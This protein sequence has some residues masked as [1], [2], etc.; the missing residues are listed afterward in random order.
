M[1]A[2]RSSRPINR[3]VEFLGDRWSLLIVRD[4]APLGSQGLR[5]LRIQLVPLLFE[6]AQI[7]SVLDPSTGSTVARFQGRHG[8]TEK[9]SAPMIEL[10][11]RE[12]RTGS[13]A[14]GGHAGSA[15]GRRA[16][17]ERVEEG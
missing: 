11:E 2:R 15:H 10:R 5:G 3:G 1:A 8:D 13:G 17:L 4:M 12:G 14:A 6:P 16:H 9:V 7:R